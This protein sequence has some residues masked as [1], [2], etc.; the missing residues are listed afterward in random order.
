MAL[1]RRR[2]Q[3]H[4]RTPAGAAAAFATAVLAAVVAAAPLVA[5]TDPRA[6]RLPDTAERWIRAETAHLTL[7]SNA[8]EEATVEIGRRIE[9]YRAVLARISPALTVDSP[10]PT[11]IF[12]FRNAISFDPYKLLRKGELSGLTANLDGYFIQHSEGNYIA[13]NA[14]A[15][16]DPW[17]VIYHE[18][19][20]FFVYN[21]FTHI[22]LWL[23]EGLAE[24]YGTFQPEGTSA[25]IG[26]A[27]KAHQQWLKDH[28][29]MPLPRLFAV[30]FDSA[31]YQQPGR[32]ETFYAESWALAHF[33]I[34]GPAS[35]G[36]PAG[37]GG[38]GIDFLRG[39]PRGGSL[40]QAIAPT[41]A[42]PAALE[43]RL[44]NHLRSRR[45]AFNEI[46]LGA[47]QPGAAARVTPI[48][49]P[50]TL[51]RL[52]DLLLHSDTGRLADAEA[53]FREA[54]RLKPSHALAHAGLGQALVGRG[55]TVE[56]RAAFEQA[57]TLDPEDPGIA[58]KFAMALVD[59]AAPR[60]TGRVFAADAMPPDLVRG[61]AL[62]ER[63]TRTAPGVAEAW[64]GLGSTYA[65]A[66]G[67]VAPGIAALERASTMMPSRADIAVNLCWLYVRSDQR[68]R[69]RD[70]N[71]RVIS[72]SSD[73]AVRMAGKEAVFWADVDEAT[74]ALEGD[75]PEAG[76]QRLRHL[77][78]TAP[79]PGL[80]E[81]VEAQLRESQSFT[82]RRREIEAYNE[83]VKMANAGD[84]DGAARR[85]EE[86]L[87][88]SPG[89]K[90]A[91]EARDLLAEV[92][93]VSLYNGAVEKAR[94]KDYRGALAL[95][96]RMP[97]EVK[98][99]PVVEAA[100][101]LRKQVKAAMSQAPAR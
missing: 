16:N 59:G 58:M 68:D 71:D 45:F 69:A 11:S 26:G 1:T 30:G 94:A 50:E 14:T 73:P 29:L 83:A 7:Y 9:L 10:L 60:G 86:M 3:A 27:I 31:D 64:A 66:A 17:P 43:E 41:I 28:P 90:A 70:L 78:A 4:L 93:A 49:R 98:D 52:G 15:D 80:K 12:I 79:T 101:T 57:F 89:P 72:R 23:S 61:R 99:H 88:G 35:V 92:R 47:P 91:G 22:P 97:S 74:T 95:L 2:C 75:Q 5:G 37:A 96:D 13:V 8:S 21:N 33:L 32:Q 81:E 100:A 51:Y 84:F 55:R 40:A 18:Y 87:K 76:L 6:P 82:G 42:D 53:H 24:C 46:D 67:D 56:A 54:V 20:H 65:Y 44:G 36:G 38:S 77:A 62:F 63:I 85:L 48:A 39:L 34:W 25:R 19:F